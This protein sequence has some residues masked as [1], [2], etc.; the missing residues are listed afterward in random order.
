MFPVQHYYSIFFHF[1]YWREN[2]DEKTQEE[3]RIRQKFSAKGYV[4]KSNGMKNETT[5]HE[6]KIIE[7]KKIDL[8]RK[9]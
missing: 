2:F 3:N 5:I 7:F 8:R 1:H 6:S 4:C 9:V